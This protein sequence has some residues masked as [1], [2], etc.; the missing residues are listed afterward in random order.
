MPE[1]T[2]S[3]H[4]CSQQM[5]MIQTCP[6]TICDVNR[7]YCTY[8]EFEGCPLKVYDGI[9]LSLKSID[10]PFM[11]SKK[12]SVLKIRGSPYFSWIPQRMY[13][14]FRFPFEVM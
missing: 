12:R 9:Q 13:V 1:T 2:Y 7:R 8:L 6:L 5:S 11:P 14:C 3:E 4:C 10:L